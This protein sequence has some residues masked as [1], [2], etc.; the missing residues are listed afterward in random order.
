VG[1]EVYPKCIISHKGRIPTNDQI[2]SG[3]DIYN[4]KKPSQI[5]LFER[6]HFFGNRQHYVENKFSYYKLN[7]ITSKDLLAG[8]ND[9]L[10]RMSA[11]E[12]IQHVYI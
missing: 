2:T 8:S 1:R 11:E 10:R 4:R 7:Q 5:R 12:G 9:E 6:M 3:G